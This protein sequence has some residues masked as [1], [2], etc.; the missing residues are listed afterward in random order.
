MPSGKSDV[1]GWL[2]CESHALEEDQSSFHWFHLRFLEF[3]VPGAFFSHF[4]SL[5]LVCG[6]SV[7][8]CLPPQVEQK[9]THRALR[10]QMRFG[11]VSLQ[12]PALNPLHRF[13]GMFSAAL[14]TAG[15]HPYHDLYMLNT[16]IYIYTYNIYALVHIYGV[17]QGGPSVP[18]IVGPSEPPAPP[19]PIRV[20]PG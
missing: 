13:A 14:T 9:C 11:P 18:L 16:Y 4:L 3:Q 17:D 1:V 8:A 12:P 7:A 19:P 5:A 15:P 6:H 2:R 10:G 20:S